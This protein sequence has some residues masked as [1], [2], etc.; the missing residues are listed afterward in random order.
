MNLKDIFVRQ[1]QCSDPDVLNVLVKTLPK[2][3]QKILPEAI[4]NLLRAPKTPLS[5]ED[6]DSESCESESDLSDHSDHSDSE[7]E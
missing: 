3:P 4:R 2:R 1:T 7:S 5:L 6:S